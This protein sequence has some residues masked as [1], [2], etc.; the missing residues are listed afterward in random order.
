MSADVFRWEP[1]GPRTL[2]DRRED[3]KLHKETLE[4]VS[5]LRQRFSDAVKDATDAETARKNLT[6]EMIWHA[7]RLGVRIDKL[8]K[9][10]PLRAMSDVLGA[11]DDDKRLDRVLDLHSSFE[12]AMARF[13]DS[14]FELVEMLIGRK[15]IEAQQIH[16]LAQKADL[17]LSDMAS[18]IQILAQQGSLGHDLRLPQQMYDPASP[19]ANP[20]V[21][22]SQRVPIFSRGSELE[23]LSAFLHEI[24][25]AKEGPT[26]WLWHG[27]AGQGKSRI[28]HRLCLDARAAGWT[29]GFLLGRQTNLADW[30]RLS[31]RRDTLVVIDYAGER[32]EETALAIARL[33]ESWKSSPHRLRFL[34]L[35][36]A[37]DGPWRETFDRCGGS[38]PQKNLLA[39]A[40]YD[41]PVKLMAPSDDSLKRI[42]EYVFT[43][44]GQTFDPDAAHDV[45]THVDREKR[46]LYAAMV[47]DAIADHGIE[48]VGRW[49]I[50]RLH[51]HILTTEIA[52]WHRSGVDRAHMNALALAT[53]LGRLDVE[54]GAAPIEILQGT[55]LIPGENPERNEVH[56]Q[57]LANFAD[58]AHASGHS[59]LPGIQPD[60]L[61][62]AYVVGRLQGELKFASEAAESI[63]KQTSLLI[64]AAWSADPI[65]TANWIMLCLRDLPL[66]SI[67]AGLFAVPVP[68]TKS[69]EVREAYAG[70]LWQASYLAATGVVASKDDRQAVWWAM[71][72]FRTLEAQPGSIPAL[73]EAWAYG[74][75][76]AIFKSDADGATIKGWLEQIKLLSESHPKEPALREAWAK[77]LQS[78]IGYAGAD[79]ATIKGWLEQMKLLSESH[80][81]EPALHEAWAYGLMNAIGY[82]GADGAT[83]T[84]WLGTLQTLSESKPNDPALREAWAVGLQ[85]AIGYAGADGA[86]IKGWLEQMK[87]LSESHPKEPALREAWAV[88]LQNAIGYA[89][90]D[91]ATIT[92]W[93]GTLQTLSESKPNDP[94]LREA[95]AK[96]LQN[97]I[98]YAGADGATIKGWLEQMKLL[99][100]SHPKEPALREAWA[101]GLAN[102]IFKSDADGATI[103]GWLEQIKLL[104]ESHPKEPALREAWV[105]GLANAI[106]KSDAD[107]AG[108]LALAV[109]RAEELVSL[110]A[111]VLA[112]ESM[113]PELQA[114]FDAALKLAAERGDADAERRLRAEWDALYGPA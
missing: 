106:F 11:L 48:A 89:G 98:G 12:A 8:E 104:S 58:A 114:V 109:L 63:K 5:E 77:G 72:E 49:N 57:R 1:S 52:K 45:L 70:L 64:A 73:H 86:T 25:P 24:S 91:G 15:L 35:E 107:D 95:W 16:A 111:A 43:E 62:E 76:N 105:K 53:V 18:E 96:G 46:S 82:A 31:L 87:L 42:M 81:K 99:S 55:G 83:I 61:G 101:K 47:A 97:A 108:N 38:D 39:G 32:P 54:S 67:A 7:N 84:G 51:E 75:M 56:W 3:A 90:A 2:R 59:P 36:R 14:R 113:I 79:G 80:P 33:H 102:A 44:R 92:G 37:A 29:A 50:T 21:Y 103:K 74:L 22:T 9:E 27:P 17:M 68:C 13:I 88:G 112:Q 30:Q 60:V 26:W 66:A 6:I 69:P 85:N 71:K 65:R 78:A 10:H 19:P 20:F 41:G 40:M 94:A 28:A 4:G 34:L 23:R 100:E 110:R 93:L